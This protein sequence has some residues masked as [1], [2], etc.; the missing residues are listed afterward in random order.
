MR[1][2]QENWISHQNNRRTH[3]KYPSSGKTKKD[4]GVRGLGLQ[5]ERKATD[6]EMEKKVNK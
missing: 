5:M 4:V 6:M 2:T 3:L 1:E